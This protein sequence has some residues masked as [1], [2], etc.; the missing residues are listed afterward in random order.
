MS[1]TTQKEVVPSGNPVVAEREKQ[2]SLDKRED[3]TTRLVFADWLE[4]H[5]DTPRADFIRVQ[6]ELASAKLAKKRRHALRV[7]ERELL[8]AHRQQWCQAFGL[9]IE[10]VHFERGLI[11]KMRLSQWKGRNVFDAAGTQRLAT[12]T[13]LDL[14]GLR[15]GDDDVTTFA[16]TASLP[17]L[18]RLLLND[19]DITDAGA[20]ALASATGLPCLNTIYLFHNPIGDGARAALKRGTG[21]CLTNLDLGE[22]AEGY[23][24]SSGEAE[25]ARRQY[26]RTSLLSV[27]SRYFKTYERLRSA[28]LCVA[29]YW[30]DEADDAV[31]GELIVSELFEPILEG[32]GYDSSVDT[33]VPNT[34][35][36]SDYGELSSVVSLYDAGVGWDD[37]GGAIPLWAA[38][39]PEEGRQEY[40][41]LSEVYAPAVLFY[42]HGG[43]EILPMARPHLDGVRPEWGLEE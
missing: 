33:N 36:K 11:V 30:D 38:F 7:R 32:V 6:C 28:M 14:S 42:R 12:L 20:I 8:D 25:M 29:Q 24:M 41:Q 40:E 4:E 27:V 43:Y 16:K 17:S 1:L 31:H 34:R 19:N 23:C 2:S 21:F 13:E 39:A 18:R 5:G 26:L 37:N 22:R 9:P 10:D 35:I 3:N 15:L